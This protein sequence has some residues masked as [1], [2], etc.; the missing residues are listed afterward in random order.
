MLNSGHDQHKI[1]DM[2]KCLNLNVQMPIHGNLMIWL[3]WIKISSSILYLFLCKGTYQC[4]KANYE[5]IFCPTSNPSPSPPGPNPPP[6]PPPSGNV[7]NGQTFDP[8]AYWCDDSRLCPIGQNACG[9]NPYAC[10]NPSKYQCVNGQLRSNRR[11]HF[12]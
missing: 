9:S 3:V 12:Y 2:M 1:R 11:R 5:I 6:P 8:N 7:C 10:Y 4:S